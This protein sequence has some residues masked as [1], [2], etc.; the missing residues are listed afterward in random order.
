MRMAEKRTKAVDQAFAAADDGRGLYL[1]VFSHAE[2]ELAKIGPPAVHR[3]RKAAIARFGEV[4]FPTTHDEEWRFT[5][6]AP[7]TRVPFKPGFLEPEGAVTDAPNFP[8]MIFINGLCRQEYRSKSLPPGVVVGRLSQAFAQTPS[9]VERYLTRL[10]RTDASP[11]T[12]LN[13]AFLHD[14]AFV[15][16]PRGV[17]VEEPV[18]LTFGCDVVR[19]PLVPHSRVL[20]RGGRRPGYARRGLRGVW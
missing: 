14:G 8:Q 1:A 2:K 16:V 19:D 7:L 5:N 3:A 6:I 17:V 12:A 11:F 20:V 18:C 15:Y 10:A 13:T 9:L 4:G